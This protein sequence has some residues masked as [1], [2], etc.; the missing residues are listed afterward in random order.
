MEEKNRQ[1]VLSIGYLG[2]RLE[3]RKL[4]VTNVEGLAGSGV[5]KGSGLGRLGDGLAVG[6]E[7][8]LSSRRS[9]SNVVKADLQA[10][11]ALEVDL[12]AV[13]LDD[14]DLDTLVDSIGNLVRGARSKK[15]RGVGSLIGREGTVNDTLGR[16]SHDNETTD[17]LSGD[18]DVD[19][20]GA[21]NL[22]DVELDVDE[23]TSGAAISTL[24]KTATTSAAG[25]VETVDGG[26]S[27]AG[28]LALRH[29]PVL[30]SSVG[31]TEAL[32]ALN[33]LRGVEGTLGSVERLERRVLGD[34]GA[35]RSRVSRAT[36][37]GAAERRLGRVHSLPVGPKTVDLGVVQ[38]EERVETR[39]FGGEE[40]ASTRSIPVNGV[41]NL[42]ERSTVGTSGSELVEG[43]GSGHDIVNPLL[44]GSPAKESVGGGGEAV[45]SR[46][47]VDSVA[48]LVIPV[49]V[50]SVESFLG[51][52]V[53][54]ER[55]L[56]VDG[57]ETAAVRD[58][59]VDVGLGKNSRNAINGPIPVGSSQFV[60]CINVLRT[61]LGRIKV[62]ESLGVLDENLLVK[63]DVRSV[64]GQED[65]LSVRTVSRPAVA[66]S[67]TTAVPLDEWLAV[68]TSNLEIRLPIGLLGIVHGA[69]GSHVKVQSGTT[70]VDKV[71]DVAASRNG[72]STS[73]WNTSN[74]D[75]LLLSLGRVDSSNN[76]QSGN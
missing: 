57:L 50:L 60:G 58:L 63:Q 23:V 52:V 34:A 10:G 62:G 75:V 70:R 65:A 46:A 39:E 55:V 76:R 44:V 59:D 24:I 31:V 32:D 47:V 30:K 18:V 7:V 19:L 14:L 71:I 25:S 43:G 21:L 36:S 3:R 6:G 8:V 49:S 68:N 40:L 37:V 27:R 53:S 29:A 1:R 13:Q 74:E 67:A 2:R 20:S 5:G 35:L 4:P 66:V 56:H 54:V 48:I 17:K 15:L 51:E 73:D 69:D 41:V 9:V 33:S 11:D 72:T 38:P 42:L 45:G 28:K 26:S 16:L 22:G 12:V 64:P 61:V